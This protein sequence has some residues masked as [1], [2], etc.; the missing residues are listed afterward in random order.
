FRTKK[1]YEAVIKDVV[2]DLVKAICQLE[3]IQTK[4]INIVFDDSIIEDENTL[5]ER[6]LKLYKENVIS[7]DTFLNKYLHLDDEQIKEE[8]QKILSNI[9]VVI[10]LLGSEIIDKE[11]AIEL[12]LAEIDE[13]EKARILANLGEVTFETEET[14][15]EE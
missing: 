11:K 14:P 6:G 7:L 5:I 1:T 8:K 4:S 15:L 13:K 9:N 3:G 10:E 12:L 2:Y